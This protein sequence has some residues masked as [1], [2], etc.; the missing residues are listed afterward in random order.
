MERR[1]ADSEKGITMCEEKTYTEEWDDGKTI[2]EMIMATNFDTMSR[3][4]MAFE[5]G[6]LEAVRR[7]VKATDDYALKKDV[8]MTMLGVEN[9]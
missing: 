5:C 6:I 1:C 7:Y 3:E 4:T 8:L 9:E 2:K